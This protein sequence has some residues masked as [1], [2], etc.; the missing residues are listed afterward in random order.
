MQTIL[1]VSIQHFDSIVN[2]FNAFL[3]LLVW[4]LHCHIDFHAELGMSIVLKVG[5]YS[6]MAPV[7]RNFPTCQS[8]YTSSIDPIEI[9]SSAHISYPVSTLLT[10]CILCFIHVQ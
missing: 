4:L 7:P 6:Q 5:E 1:E 8:D 2:Q 9:N 3:L 10:I